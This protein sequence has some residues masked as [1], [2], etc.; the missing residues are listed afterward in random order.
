MKICTRALSVL[1]LLCAFS[2]CLF[3][4]GVV[5]AVMT[6]A[7]AFDLVLG[8]LGGDLPERWRRR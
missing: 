1:G 8:A 6:V 5:L 4:I 7:L 3:G 2:A